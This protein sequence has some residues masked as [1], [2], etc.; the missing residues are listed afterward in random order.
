MI[1]EATTHTNTRARYAAG[2]GDVGVTIS[3]TNQFDVQL[4][5]SSAALAGL[6]VLLADCPRFV[7]DTETDRLSAVSGQLVGVAVAVS[8]HAA[9]Y[10]AALGMGA[11]TFSLAELFARLGAVF[12]NDALKI[13]HNIRYD[14]NVL[15][16][17]GLP[18][19]GPTFDTLVAAHVLSSERESFA[20]ASQTKAK[21]GFE[22]PP[23]GPLLEGGARKNSLI[24]APIVQV[25][26]YAGE[27]VIATWRL[28]ELFSEQLAGQTARAYLNDEIE[29][30]LVR[31]LAEMEAAGMRVDVGKL[32]ALNAEWG[33]EMMRLR[34]EAVKLV[35][36]EFN[37][38]SPVQ[39]SRILFDELRLKPPARGNKSVDA[40]A[41]RKLA[42]H[43]NGRTLPRVLLDYREAAKLRGTYAD[44]LPRAVN[45]ATGKIHCSLH[46]SGTVTGRLSCSDPNLQNIPIR[47][48]RGRRLRDAF[49]P[50]P[51]CALIVA[52]YSQI[53]LRTLA[54]FSR[55]KV[56]C[57]GFNAGDDVHA[58]VAAEINGVPL[59]KVTPKQRGQAKTT[60]FAVIY[61]QGAPALAEAL[62]WPIDRARAFIKRY[63]EGLPGVAK[64]IET[65]FTEARETGGVLTLFGRFR[66]IRGAGPN[67][68]KVE[69]AKARR[70]AVNTVCSGSAAEIV[71]I[72]MI[73]LSRRIERDGL[74]LVP[75]LQVHD[76]IIAEAPLAAA[77]RLAEVMRDVM[78]NAVTLDVPLAVDVG[79]GPT[80]LKAKA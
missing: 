55:D 29:Q 10:V 46:Q 67:A 54:H 9:Y 73:E 3:A 34:A 14:I 1:A 25:G 31:V 13:G 51:G 28:W 80:W 36:Y 41:L 62:K 75:I 66:R 53:E 74:P 68:N 48:E 60:N 39:V 18:L 32:N 23:I 63:F 64:F 69:A 15:R 76:E 30:P 33:E 52:D 4:V 11:P 6:A 61:G 50:S 45:P 72:A 35:G 5:D 20:L 22:L 59:D 70:L 27:Q 2:Y 12:A 38:D 56:L 42:A 71:K 24:D 16:G 78:V 47:S 21:L 65:C 8:E 7:V 57:D 17:N 37:L 79:I 58:R 43:C 26:A 49:V 19:G 40:S 77:A 44:A